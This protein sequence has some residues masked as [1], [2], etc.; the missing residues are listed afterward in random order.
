MSDESRLVT[1][2]DDDE[3]PKEWGLTGLYWGIV[4]DNVDP[5]G[6]G[7]VTAHVPGITTQASYWLE[8]VGLPGSGGSQRGTYYP[9]AIGATVLVGYIQ[10]DLNE[11]VYWGGP[12]PGDALPQDNK[13][14]NVIHQTT[15]FRI[16]VQEE[17]GKQ[18]VRVETLLPGKTDLERATA[19]SFMELTITGGKDGHAHVINAFAASGMHL[20]SAGAIVIDA[21]IV[22]IKGRNVSPSTKAI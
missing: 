20:K 14:E 22:Q 7:R 16:L 21:P 13:P 5:D 18:R 6:R 19:Q 2:P 1:H 12:P 3:P 11:G 9:P 8:P 17:P 10:G 4:I 15:N